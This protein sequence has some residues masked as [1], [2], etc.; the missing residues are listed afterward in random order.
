MISKRFLSIAIILAAVCAPLSAKLNLPTKKLGK[1]T[2]YYYEVKKNETIFDIATKIG[3]SKDD[4]VKYNP[5][6]INGVAKKQLLFLP[7]K[8]FDAAQQP[9]TGTDVNTA[10]LE[11]ST[12]HYVKS[13]ESVYGI[14]K[15][16]GVTEKD[17]LA[18]NPLMSSGIKEGD[19]LNIPNKLVSNNQ[20][21][22]IFHTL[23]AGE[24]LFS[25]AKKYNTTIEQLVE[26]NPGIS[27]NNLVENDVIRII[28]N[29]PKSVIVNKDYD[30]VVSYVVQ[31]N[32]TYESV[33]AAYGMPV[34]Q[35]KSANPD[36]KKLKKGK[37]IYI[38][39]KTVDQV[40][41]NTSALT[42]KQLE[43]AYKG[44]LDDIYSEVIAPNKNDSIDIAI[45]LPFQ[46]GMK[47]Q[48]RN[49]RN[50]V[51]FLNGFVLALDSADVAKLPKPMNLN[52]YDTKH[53]LDTTDSILCLQKLKLSDLIIA[54]SEPKQ[55]ERILNYGKDNNIN[56]LNCF[57]T[58][59]DD[60]ISNSRVMQAN[61]PSPYLN[62]RINE[63]LDEKFK[64][65]VLVYLEE[66]GVENKD[67]FDDIKQHATQVKHQ[68]KTITV[69]SELTGK[70]LSKYLEPGS[71]YIFIPAN[72]KESLLKKFAAGLRD[73]K[74]TRVDCDIVL[75]GH[76]EYTMY[77]KAY[78]NTFMDIDTYIYSRF[79]LPDDK[80]VTE[81]NSKYAD[82]Y[83]VKPANS[84]PNMS[85]FGYDVAKFLV[86]AFASGKVPGQK[87][88]EYN[89]IQT[90]FDFERANN[91]AGY[92]NKS[93]RIV[94]L[95]PKN[96]LI[97][98]D[99]ND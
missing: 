71:S 18:A 55:L 40:V 52:V 21:Q 56:I 81:F 65:Y 76:P 47:E 59:N 35:L 90:N 16:Y 73:A 89:G 45:I 77:L 53:S 41:V 95:T 42:Q 26:S 27:G 31:K 63:Y 78:K 5:Q 82:K 24:S 98:E 80:S 93:V 91:W 96:E 34:D 88:S 25:I 17:L 15:A 66:P 72:G 57:A 49:A 1:E 94:H 48:T 4:I 32:D 86:N 68:N 13:G 19:V 97:I 74:K 7:A 11:S 9:T 92:I 29:T 36:Q 2:F 67:I 46:V 3:V 44:K 51:E 54:P 83:R 39:R 87:G 64:D 61:I 79:Y 38:P 20:G 70:A 6:A 60:Y 75:L 99:L 28:P 85:V 14:A 10:L 12:K 50:Y 43:D 69:S 58:Q 33:A 62:A 37:T 23:A 30:Q 8:E 22:Y 84:T